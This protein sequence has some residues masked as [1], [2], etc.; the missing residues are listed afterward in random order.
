MRFCKLGETLGA[1]VTGLNLQAP[2]GRREIDQLMKKWSR[3]GVLV[4][5]GQRI[6]DEEQVRFARRLGRLE[7]FTPRKENVPFIPEI[8]RSSNTDELGQLLPSHDE[9]I[10]MLRLNWLWHIDSSY[11]ELPIKGVVLR[12]LHV[13]EEGGDTIFADNVTAFEKLPSVMKRRIE[14]LR[15]IHNFAYLVRQQGDDLRPEE[16]VSLP[17]T[18]HPLVRRHADGRRS[19]YLSPPYMEKIVGWSDADSHT[20]IHELMAWATQENFLFR[21]RWLPHDVIMWDNA[22]TMHR[23]TPYDVTRHIRA[24]HGVTIL[25]EKPVLP[26]K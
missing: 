9:R 16:A 10:K 26:Q 25:G 8:F 24:V 11:R 18:E 22:W 21:H 3:H 14:S 6:T 17:R 12:A 1:E 2:H 5:R 4:F 20:L 13:A 15:A 23:V 7:T 19:L